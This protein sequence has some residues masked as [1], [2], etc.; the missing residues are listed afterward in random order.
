MNDSGTLNVIKNDSLKLFPYGYKREDNQYGFSGAISFNC[1][2]SFVLKEENNLGR[3]SINETWFNL[4]NNIL[5]ASRDST[6]K[7]EEAFEE[8]LSTFE[9]K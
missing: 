3:N 7:E 4:F 6:S 8:Y 1:N 9:V 2:S 5:A